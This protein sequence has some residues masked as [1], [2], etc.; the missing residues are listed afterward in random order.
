MTVRASTMTDVGPHD[1]YSTRDQAYSISR[2]ADGRLLA[3]EAGLTRPYDPSY[4]PASTD[5]AGLAVKI[6]R[7]SVAFAPGSFRGAKDDVHSTW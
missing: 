2:S 5:V 3:S 1:A 4:S 6:A 7:V